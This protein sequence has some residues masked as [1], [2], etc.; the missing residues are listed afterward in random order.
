M[1]RRSMLLKALAATPADVQRVVKIADPSAPRRQAAAATLAQMIDFEV[2][3]R[4]QLSRVVQEAHPQLPELAL[5]PAWLA[6]AEDPGTES[7]VDRFVAVRQET[8]DYLDGLS[9][10]DWQ[11]KLA[12]ATLGE[13][14][15]RYLVQHLVDHDNRHLGMLMGQPPQAVPP[16]PPA[17]RMAADL[18]D[19][20]SQP[21]NEVRNERKRIRKRSRRRI[22]GD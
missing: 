5:G 20:D 21:H 16:V 1:T 11:H 18:R 2:R 6:A 4:A 17:R 7:L 8:L 12:H 14:S 10:G 15:F 3:F 13:T 22:R 9:P 19:A